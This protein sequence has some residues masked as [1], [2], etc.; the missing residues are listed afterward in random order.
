MF[1]LWLL[2]HL[3]YSLIRLIAFEVIITIV[4]STEEIYILGIWFWFASRSFFRS[5]PTVYQDSFFRMIITWLTWSTGFG[6]LIKVFYLKCKHFRIVQMFY[7]RWTSLIL[8]YCLWSLF[9]YILNLVV[10]RYFW[11]RFILYQAIN[12]ILAHKLSPRLILVCL[13]YHNISL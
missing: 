1:R 13:S 12:F 8:I 5:M 9:L 6:F 4:Y 2:I 11:S 7:F 10:V 3:T